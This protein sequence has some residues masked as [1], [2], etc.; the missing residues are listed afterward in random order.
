MKKPQSLYLRT[1]PHNRLSSYIENALDGSGTLNGFIAYVEEEAARLLGPAKPDISNLEGDPADHALTAVTKLTFDYLRQPL[2]EY[3]KRWEEFTGSL[4]WFEQN[5]V[6][7]HIIGLLALVPYRSLWAADYRRRDPKPHEHLF[8]FKSVH[9]ALQRLESPFTLDDF[10]EE[11]TVAGLPSHRQVARRSSLDFVGLDR[12]EPVSIYL[13]EAAHQIIYRAFGNEFYERLVHTLLWILENPNVGEDVSAGAAF[14]ETG[15]TGVTAD[16]LREKALDR[17]RLFA[18][19]LGSW[20]PS[21][22][23]YEQVSDKT[24]DANAKKAGFT[25]LQA[26]ELLSDFLNKTNFRRAD[27][28]SVEALDFNYSDNP[29][30]HAELQVLRFADQLGL[31]DGTDVGELPARVT[32]VLAKRY[33]ITEIVP[34]RDNIFRLLVTRPPTD[35]VG[36]DLTNAVDFHFWS[37]FQR[38]VDRCFSHLPEDHPRKSRAVL[39]TLAQPVLFER[40]AAL[41]VFTGAKVSKTSEGRWQLHKGKKLV[42]EL[43]NRYGLA[44]GTVLANLVALYDPVTTSGEWGRLEVK[45]SEI[46]TASESASLPCGLDYIDQARKHLEKNNGDAQ[47]AAADMATEI[48]AGWS[49]ATH[50]KQGKGKRSE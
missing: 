45:A 50:G 16:G 34:T 28:E 27:A 5:P 21:E 14:L 40:S 42:L 46:L 8:D 19:G 30:T 49:R 29:F 24:L 3:L 20:P 25:G 23:N 38:Y 6:G 17:S 12:R 4:R 7:A 18:H 2:D 39:A 44:V 11:T 9:Q 36:A 41:G 26:P 1:V 43:E 31:I 47:M 48:A 37:L 22:A 13:D 32:T 15:A 33:G 10:V 35:Q